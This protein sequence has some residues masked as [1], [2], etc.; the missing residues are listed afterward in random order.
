[1]CAELLNQNKTADAEAVEVYRYGRI[2][3]P[4]IGRR[5][6]FSDARKPHVLAGRGT[7][8]IIN[9]CSNL[10]LRETES[11]VLRKVLE[12]KWDE[13]TGEWRRLHNEELYDLY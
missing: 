8:T 1:M 10:R 2:L 9:G 13:A 5:S 12:L 11:R 3:R 7:I 4:Y 6:S